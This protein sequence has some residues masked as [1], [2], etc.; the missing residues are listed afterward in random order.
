M[1]NGMSLSF[2]WFGRKLPG[3][4]LGRD[5]GESL[6]VSVVAVRWCHSDSPAAGRL[7]SSCCP[8]ALPLGPHFLGCLLAND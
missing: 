1:N 5:I 4:H 6:E 8:A 3:A 7:S 2:N